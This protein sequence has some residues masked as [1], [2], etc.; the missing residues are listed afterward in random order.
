[1]DNRNI[2]EGAMKSM[3]L[4]RK[5]KERLDKDYPMVTSKRPKTER[6][7]KA[8]A[9]GGGVYRIPREKYSPR[10]H[11]LAEVEGSHPRSDKERKLAAMA[12]PKDKITHKDVLVGRGVLKKEETSEYSAKEARAGKD[13]GKPGKQFSQI[14]KEAGKRYGSKE[15]GK[16]VAGA[17]LAKLRRE[18]ES[19]IA[20]NKNDSEKEKRLKTMHNDSAKELKKLRETID[21]ISSNNFSAPELKEAI[22]AVIS[23]KV[24]RRLEEIKESIASNYFCSPSFKE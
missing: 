3:D 11:N 15:A 16:R 2:S 9:G 19:P 20:V 13:I 22:G 24:N 17:V 21:M 10:K 23:S 18:D 8:A 1:M 7:K 4:E 5:E 12:H 14:A 6:G